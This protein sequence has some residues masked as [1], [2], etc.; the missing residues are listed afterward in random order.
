MGQAID[1]TQTLTL[2]EE[3]G[4]VFNMNILIAGTSRQ[5]LDDAIFDMAFSARPTVRIDLLVTTGESTVDINHVNEYGKEVERQGR[6][7]PWFSTLLYEQGE[8]VAI[9]AQAG[10]E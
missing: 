1:S 9:S 2:G 3:T 10:R 8:T 4:C 5:I 6:P 7:L